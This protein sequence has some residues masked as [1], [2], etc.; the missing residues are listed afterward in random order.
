M[1]IVL[2]VVIEL[3]YYKYI[4]K[5]VKEKPPIN[6]MPLVIEVDSIYANLTLY[7]NST[8]QC[9]NSPNYTASG[10]E[11]TTP[12]RWIAISR[13]IKSEYNLNWGDTLY[14]ESDVLPYFNGPWVVHD[15]SSPRNKR[16][17]EILISNPHQIK[18]GF[19]V[20]NQLFIKYGLK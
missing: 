14:L 13:D 19:S 4:T 9:D 5:R 10:E 7:N 2:G 11:I 6:D 17:I 1:L 16:L 18:V 12:K 20:K 8:R 3:Y 15:V